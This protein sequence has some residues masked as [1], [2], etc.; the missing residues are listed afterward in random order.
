MENT[1]ISSNSTVDEDSIKKTIKQTKAGYVW[2]Y[3]QGPII[4]YGFSPTES[5][6]NTDL[7]TA[8][9][10]QYLT[11]D[12]WFPVF[13]DSYKERQGLK[14]STVAKYKQLYN[15]FI[16]NEIGAARLI[17]VKSVDVEDLIKS[18]TYS[19]T[20]PITVDGVKTL[21][22]RILEAAFLEGLIDENPFLRAAPVK[23]KRKAK[24]RQAFTDEEQ[25]VF[26]FRA[27]KQKNRGAEIAIKIS[28]WTGLRIGEV[29][30]LQ[31]KDID[32]QRNVIY[33][34]N[35][36]S[37]V[38][39]ETSLDSTKNDSGR[40]AIPV[41]PERLA[42]VK[43]WKEN[44]ARKELAKGAEKQWKQLVFLS[45][46]STPIAASTYSRIAA[47]IIKSMKRDGILNSSLEYCFHSLRHSFASRGVRNHM[48]PKTLC[49]LMGHG[50]IRTTMDLYAHTYIE[51]NR[52]ELEKCRMY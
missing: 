5:Q 42:E 45:R 8:I 19:E 46:V 47:D 48:E 50:S 32:F 24:E 23:N 35:N 13:L 40:R 29:V 21:L 27:E 30:G 51:D 43:R 16:S 11:V 22:N 38:E 37:Y 3:S 17:D 20:S 15:G 12:E 7:E 6:A 39:R 25:A 33:V 41:S 49:D 31:W 44:S 4:R 14:R 9:H 36:L 28:S 26:I 34:R 52:K 18:I 2:Y 10:F 1:N